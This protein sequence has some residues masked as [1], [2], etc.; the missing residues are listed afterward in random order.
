V[1]LAVGTGIGAGILADG[2][3]LRGA[4]DSAGARAGWR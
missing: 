4:H 3:I 2:Q 1:F